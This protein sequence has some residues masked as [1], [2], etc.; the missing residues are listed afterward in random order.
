MFNSVAKLA[1]LTWGSMGIWSLTWSGK[2]DWWKSLLT[3]EIISYIIN[4]F[5]SPTL[6]SG[7]IWLDKLDF[8]VLF[9]SSSVHVFH[10]KRLLLARQ[11]PYYVRCLATGEH[12]L[13]FRHPRQYF[14]R[15]R[16][17]HCPVCEYLTEVVTFRLIYS[18]CDCLVSRLA[19][20]T[21]L[22]THR[23]C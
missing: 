18:W 21:E 11:Q 15:R 6:K 19:C 8:L 4:Y 20:S 22:T 17:L 16:R 5:T 12:F 10:Q 2:K 14:R 7:F 9:S 3:Y 1:I 13:H 23:F